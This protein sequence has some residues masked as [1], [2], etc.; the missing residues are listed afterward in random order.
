[1]VCAVL[2]ICVLTIVV[3]PQVDLPPM[4]LRAISSLLVHLA[5]LVLLFLLGIQLNRARLDLP[6]LGETTARPLLLRLSI[7]CVRLC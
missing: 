3:A 5:A 4:T 1:M 2:L 7:I 6:L